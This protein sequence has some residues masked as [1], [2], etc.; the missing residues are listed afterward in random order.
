VKVCMV[1]LFV[2]GFFVD[3]LIWEISVSLFEGRSSDYRVSFAGISLG[4]LKLERPV[5]PFCKR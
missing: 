5:A 3:G 1:D 4:R 2:A